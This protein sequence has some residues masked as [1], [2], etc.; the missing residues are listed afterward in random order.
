MMLL[1]AK[2]YLF[3]ALSVSYLLISLL[4]IFVTSDF[5]NLDAYIL[6]LF[7]VCFFCLLEI[8]IRSVNSNESRV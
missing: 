3:L 1:I 5:G 6:K 4:F 8:L 2:R 7:L